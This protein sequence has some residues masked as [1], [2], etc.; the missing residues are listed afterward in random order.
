MLNEAQYHI[1]ENVAADES[2][3]L[4]KATCTAT[5]FSVTG[6]MTSIP[7]SA[8]QCTCR[9]KRVPK[10]T[11]VASPPGNECHTAMHTGVTVQ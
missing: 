9:Q 3:H 4:N 10:K 2:L 7:F 11:E 8:I 6:F 5:K 1:Q